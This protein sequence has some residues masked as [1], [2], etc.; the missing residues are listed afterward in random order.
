VAETKSKTK[1]NK[2]SSTKA[3]APAEKKTSA[4]AKAPAKKATAKNEAKAPVT[5]ATKSSS[6][7]IEEKK[8]VVKAKKSAEPA[9]ANTT[10][11]T[12]AKAKTKTSAVASSKAETVVK[13]KTVAKSKKVDEKPKK[14]ES[15]ADQSKEVVQAKSEES[16]VVKDDSVLSAEPIK[17]KASPVES[18]E[19]SKTGKES[20]KKQNVALSFEQELQAGGYFSFRLFP[21]TDLDVYLKNRKGLKATFIKEYT[22]NEDR[23]SKKKYQ[24]ELKQVS[25]PTVSIRKKRSVH[26]ESP[27]ELIERIARELEEQKAHS[28]SDITKQKCTKCG[29]F[30]VADMFR[31]DKDLGYCEECAEILHLGETKEAR[32]V[33]YQM[34]LIRKTSLFGEGGEEE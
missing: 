31:I 33:D 19:K 32:K 2:E 18:P 10:E 12:V 24:N 7:K 22:E 27:E 25:H 3:E 26:E 9:K 34:S 23:S 30:P 28:S 29:V 5:K 14:A 15:T 4:K 16:V 8:P 11:K 21:G 20:L 6:P 17:V 13:P 1:S